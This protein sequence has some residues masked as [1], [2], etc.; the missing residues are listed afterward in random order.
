MRHAYQERLDV[1]AH[2]LLTMSDK[3]SEI[4]SLASASL[5]KLRPAKAEQARTL[6]AELEETRLRCKDSAMSL[7]ALEGPVARDLRQVVTSIYIVEDFDRMGALAKHIATTAMRRY[8]D[9]TIPEAF[10]GH[11]KEM[12][13]LC[14][15]LMRK[16]HDLLVDP[17]ADVA[18]VM[19]RDDDAV[20][21]LQKYIMT[22]VTSD[23]WEYT[24]REAVDLALLCRF[25]E[26]F[27][28]H[29]INVAEQ[30]I[31]LSTGMHPNDYRQQQ[32]SSDTH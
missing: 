29:S 20:D 22:K 11:V 19:H 24:S 28:D 3:V 10:V 2:D 4:L 16:V 7:L 9:P 5:L 1:F 32:D 15:E 13:R 12:S 6:F 17:N 27:A 8:P 18:S 30:I 14:Q 31:F 21:D 23:S 25:Y 26:R